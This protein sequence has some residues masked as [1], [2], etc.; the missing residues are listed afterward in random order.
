MANQETS[1]RAIR[2]NQCQY[3]G[4]AKTNSKM[5]FMVFFGL[6]LAGVV[7]TPLIVGALGY[8]AWALT[9]PGKFTCPSCKSLEVVKLEDIG[10]HSK[11]G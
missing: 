7:Y 5:I 6:F 1:G 3:E 11:S 4:P 8:L 2:C 10:E 9:R